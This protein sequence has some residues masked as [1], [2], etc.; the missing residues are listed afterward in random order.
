M[1]ADVEGGLALFV[2]ALQGSLAAGSAVGGVIYD[3]NGPAGPLAVA[4][5]VAAAGSLTLLSRA[6]ASIGSAPAGSAD[7]PRERGREAPAPPQAAIRGAENS[8]V[9]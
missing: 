2:S 8:A 3:A 7:L 1:P 6:G 5:V 9:K 4:A